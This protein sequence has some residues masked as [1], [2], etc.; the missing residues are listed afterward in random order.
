MGVAPR[1]KSSRKGLDKQYVW[2]GTAAPGDTLGNFGSDRVAARR[3]TYFYEEQGHYWFDTQP[4]VTKTANDYAERLREDVETVWNEITERLRAE[5]RS[6]GVFD[7]V[8]VAPASSADIPDLEDARLVI[9][10][11]R[12]S[13]RKSDGADSSAH[14]WVRD[15]IETKGASQRIHRNT[16]RLPCRRQERAGEPGSRRA[17]PTSRG[18]A[19][20]PPARASTCRCA[21]RKQT[22]DWVMRLDRTVWIESA[23]PS[24]GRSTPNSSTPPNRSS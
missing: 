4:S 15:A 2:L 11:P 16:L 9:V 18:S 1:I 22:D 3:S 19:C 20:R 13:R 23:T 17:Q 6:R 21:S 8:H 5:E 10:H 12:H 7:R 14:Q 24:C